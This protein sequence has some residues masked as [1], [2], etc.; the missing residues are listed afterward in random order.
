[1]Y[2]CSIGCLHDSRASTVPSSTMKSLVWFHSPQ[3]E[4]KK[5]E[6]KIDHEN[7]GQG[8]DRKR[9]ATGKEGD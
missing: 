5:K 3:I 9:K 4:G 6:N 2:E 8:S 1:M 7:S